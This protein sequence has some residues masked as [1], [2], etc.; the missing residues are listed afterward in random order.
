MRNMILLCACAWISACVAP[1]GE[2]DPQ[3]GY[4]DEEEVAAAVDGAP[5]LLDVRA[6]D[7][8]ERIQAAA[9]SASLTACHGYTTCAG[10]VMIGDLTGVSCGAPY[11]SFEKCA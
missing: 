8:P 6:T 7:A 10:G 9:L 2:R 1:G 11:C 4:Q 5:V 3:V